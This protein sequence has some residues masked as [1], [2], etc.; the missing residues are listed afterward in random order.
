MI[1]PTLDISYINTRCYL[2]NL[3]NVY[4]MIT[5]KV[6]ITAPKK[7]NSESRLALPLERLKIIKAP[8]FISLTVLCAIIRTIIILSNAN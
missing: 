4:T 6:L 1:L 2:H 5:V 8:I 3:S 7:N